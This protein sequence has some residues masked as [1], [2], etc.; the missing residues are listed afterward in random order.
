[1][2]KNETLNILNELDVGNASDTYDSII[3]LV[4][5]ALLTRIYMKKG[6]TLSIYLT[7]DGAE[8]DWFHHAKKKAEK[9]TNIS[10]YPPEI[11]D[12]KIKDGG[13]WNDLLKRKD[14]QCDLPEETAKEILMESVYWNEILKEADENE[15]T[16]NM[17]KVENEAV[18]KVID[19]ME[20]K[21]IELYW[22]KD[23]S[24]YFCSVQLEW[25][26]PILLSGKWKTIP[27]TYK[28]GP[29]SE[30]VMLKDGKTPPCFQ[31]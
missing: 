19:W 15:R 12:D 3:K 11:L 26:P 18:D 25:R 21:G 28:E 27:C 4:E 6:E 9:I 23:G 8:I 7:D 10:A 31:K 30:I 29:D 13:T 17:Q 16:Y 14:M 5:E 20:K 24:S 2:N 22:K 1:M